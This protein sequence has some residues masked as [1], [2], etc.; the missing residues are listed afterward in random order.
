MRTFVRRVAGRTR[1][2]GVGIAVAGLLAEPVAG[3][4]PSCDLWDADRDGVVEV[5]DV[6]GLIALRVRVR[7]CRSVDFSAAAECRALDLAQDG[8][9][10]VLDTIVLQARL[11]SVWPCLSSG[12]IRPLPP[13]CVSLDSDFDGLL[14]ASDVAYL[15]TLSARWPACASVDLSSLACQDADL[16]G[17]QRV[18]TADATIAE[19]L[20]SDFGRCVG[21][22]TTATAGLWVDRERLS[23]RPTDGPGWSALYAEAS[24]PQRVPDLSNQD[25]PANTRTL[26]KALV[27]VRLGREDLVDEVHRALREVT[28]GGSEAG[29]DT[30][31]LGREV[32]AYVFAADLIDLA[33]LDPA[34]DADFRTWLDVLRR[35]DFS[36]RTL[37][38]THEDRPNNWGTHA[39][40]TRV[41][42][43]LY[44]GDEGDLAAAVE[45]HRAWLGEAS[46]HVGFRYGS[47]DWQPDPL[48]PVAIGPRGA[49]RDGLDLDGALP[50][51]MRRGGGLSDPPVHTGYVWEALQG[52]VVTTE[53]LARHGYPDAW[54]WGDDALVRALA[55]LARTDARYGGWWATG[56]DPWIVWLVDRATGSAFLAPAGGRPGKNAGFTEWTHAPR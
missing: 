45:V 51:E 35:R 29:A 6:G 50:E 43:A 53:L 9:L 46:S 20:V 54:H 24:E 30:L 33:S 44:L 1:V 17:D 52:A 15:T 41:A 3:Q 23:E 2:L 31:A 12:A 8:R 5:A 26:A 18:S 14:T 55:W 19:G 22:R 11:Q 47:L 32:A 10:D 16:D 4:S 7:S 27:G 56:D 39:G 49:R 42:I 34:L 28:Y 21:Q 48:R 38:S 25:D 13:G 37:I 40:A 36:G